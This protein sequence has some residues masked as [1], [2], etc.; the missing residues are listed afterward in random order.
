MRE[1]RWSRIGVFCLSAATAAG[2]LLLLSA[3]A[4]G[5]LIAGVGIAELMTDGTYCGWYKYTYT[6]TW[7]LSKALSHL[8]LV[9][10]AACADGDFHFAFDTEAGGDVDGR[11]TGSGY[12]HGHPITFTVPFEGAFEPRGDPSISLGAPLIKWE[13]AGNPGKDGVGQFWF[14]SSSAPTIGLYEDVWAAKYGSCKVF[15]DLTG[16]YPSCE[17]AQHAPEAATLAYLLAG[18]A[19]MLAT[20]RQQRGGR[21]ASGR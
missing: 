15:G 9:L 10:P 18:G 8:D 17:R 21:S 20:R 3:Q 6:V 5:G 4:G 13:P 1:G 19:G 11:S 14:Y 2:V 7:D 12:R 16:A